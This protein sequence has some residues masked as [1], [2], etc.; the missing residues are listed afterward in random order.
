MTPLRVGFRYIDSRHW[1]GGFN[2][3]LNLMRALLD[4]RPQLISPVLFCG[5]EAPPEDRRVFE[6][7]LGTDLVLSSAFAP[8]SLRRRHRV[9]WTVRLLRRPGH[10]VRGR[11]GVDGYGPAGR[12]LGDDA[13]AP[14][15]LRDQ[16]HS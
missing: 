3:L 15:L 12:R 14:H 8:Q 4:A 9:R 1:Q 11:G 6:E 7:L 2:Y 10:R 13:Q 5:L 16:W